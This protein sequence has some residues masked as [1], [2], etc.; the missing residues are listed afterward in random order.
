MDDGRRGPQSL[1]WVGD[2]RQWGVTDVDEL[3]GLL[4]DIFVVGCHGGNLVADKADRGVEDRHVG[5]EAALGCVERGQHGA[6]TTES[7]S[8]G[9][10]D[11]QYSGVGVRTSEYLAIQHPR[12]LEVRRIPRLTRQLLSQVPSRDGM[13]DDSTRH[14]KP[15]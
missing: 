1:L 7:P 11:G 8:P 12:Q 15:R 14:W 6:N 3:N 9:G 4:G 2:K 13:A 5:G 10:V